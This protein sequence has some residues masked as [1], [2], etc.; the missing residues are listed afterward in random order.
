MK[1]AKGFTLI[2]VMIAVVIFGV[3]AAAISLAN[4]QVQTGAR[5]IEEQTEA[6]WVNQNYLTQLRIQNALP[7]AGE[8]SVNVEFN[9]KDW[10]I[11]VEVRNVDVELLGP[12]LRNVQL[13]AKLAGEENYADVLVAVLGEVGSP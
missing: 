4:V 5:Q 2:E 7:T 12:Y 10:V 6:R 13:K 8:T 1:N 3:T 9:N 11:D